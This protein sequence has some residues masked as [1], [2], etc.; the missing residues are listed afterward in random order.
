MA[1]KEPPNEDKE[2]GKAYTMDD[3]RQMIQKGKEKETKVIRQSISD[4]DFIF[5]DTEGRKPRERTRDP[6]LNFR[7]DVCWAK[8]N[9]AKH[10]IK[11]AWQNGDVDIMGKIE[12]VKINRIIDIPRS[13][14]AG[15][16]LKAMKLKLGKLLTTKRNIQLNIRESIGLRRVIEIPDFSMLELQIERKKTTTLRD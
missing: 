5:L 2:K 14:Y 9:K 8:A 10:I 6:R 11:N 12:N 1:N 15:N 4:H 3:S 16:R 13:M 7:Y